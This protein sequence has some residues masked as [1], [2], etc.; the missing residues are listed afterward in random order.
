MKKYITIAI[1]L[2]MAFIL[3]ACGGNTPADNN[4]P[5]P[6][7]SPLP[8]PT[9]TNPP[10]TTPADTELTADTMRDTIS[11]ETGALA[12]G[13]VALPVNN[14]VI[15]SSIHGELG[16]DYQHEITAGQLNAAGLNAETVKLYYINKTNIT[17]VTNVITKNADGGVTVTINRF[18]WYVLGDEPPVYI[19]EVDLSDTG[20]TDS[21]LAQ[22]VTSGEIPANVTHLRI[23]NNQLSDLS[24]LVGLT[25]LRQLGFWGNE[26]TDL[27]PLSG[28]T[29][30]HTLW[31]GGINVSDLTPITGLTNL[32]WL[33]LGWNQITDVTPPCGNDKA[34]G[35]TFE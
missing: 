16:F 25:D 5:A 1:A 7:P 21:Q 33:H 17:E 15:G 34:F 26:V 23:A 9:E 35:I 13:G 3:A 28:L 14:I 18:S 27:S 8:S 6:S 2:I 4:T 30:L 20:L 31:G 11:L 22:K 19:V 10:P 32:R 24:P 29:N 12:L